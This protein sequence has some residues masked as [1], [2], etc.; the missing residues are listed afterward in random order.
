MLKQNIT[1]EVFKDKVRLGS[2]TPGEL[3]LFIS[4]DDKTNFTLEDI[5]IIH[6]AMVEA[7]ESLGK[8][9]D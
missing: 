8:Q 7:N 9:N 5:A 6:E 3:C 2:I 4:H 1:Y